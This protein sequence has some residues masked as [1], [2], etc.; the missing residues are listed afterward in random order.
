MKTLLISF[1]VIAACSTSARAQVF[2]VYSGEETY[3]RFC[4]SCH[5]K[6]GEGNDALGSP[7]LAGQNVD[8]LVR[9]YNNFAN[10]SR[11]ADT[12]DKYGQ[13]MA[14]MSKVLSD[15]SAVQAVAD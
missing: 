7:S 14:A 11:G 9:Q 6:K 10:G 12:Q 1:F 4:A 8:Y 13:Q 3:F 2:E 5:G 15:E